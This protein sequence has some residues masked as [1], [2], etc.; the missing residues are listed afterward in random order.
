MSTIY[1]K[2][3]E[4]QRELQ[5]REKRLTPRARSLLILIDGRRTDEELSGLVTDF[6][7]NLQPLLEA[8]LVQPVEPAPASPEA[9]P[10]A[11]A[12][13]SPQAI[14]D[15]EAL[16][17]EALRAVNDLLGP[18]GEA[19]ALRIE[20]A[21]SGKEL[22]AALERA[23]AYIANARGGAAAAQFANRFVRTPG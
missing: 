5:T 21:P 8:G 18:T 1:T 13:E 2:T 11:T 16:R 12:N 10:R 15:R 23:V 7:D 9:A 17:R 19:L 22:D 3:A 20:K 4:G 6:G 14:A